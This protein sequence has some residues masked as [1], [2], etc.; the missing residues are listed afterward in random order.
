MN[1]APNADSDHNPVEGGAPSP[2]LLGTRGA[3]GAAP[4]K[5]FVPMSSHALTDQMRAVEQRLKSALKREAA[6]WQSREPAEFGE[7][8]R[9]V[10]TERNS[11]PQR[12]TVWLWGG[13][14]AAAAGLVFGVLLL[15]PPRP[16]DPADAPAVVM[17][18]TDTTALYAAL[19]RFP[20]L[21]H[22]P[23]PVHPV[24]DSVVVTAP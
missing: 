12:R 11:L 19:P 7:R 1:V 20:P 24:P 21:S 8:C 16:A 14:I 17:M 23:S 15:G 13:A 22:P 2:P 9:A 10:T 4:S 3:D 5:A 18:L 6:Y